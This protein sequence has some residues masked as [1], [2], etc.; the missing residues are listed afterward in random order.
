MNKFNYTASPGIAIIQEIKDKDTAPVTLT[1]QSKGKIKKGKIISMGADDITNQGGVIPAKNY[2]KTGDIVLFLSYYVEGELD[3]TKIEG[4][5]YYLTKF[6][7]IRA[8]QS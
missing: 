2:G 8:I 4:Q 3:Y 5:D 1:Q 6:G 7:D